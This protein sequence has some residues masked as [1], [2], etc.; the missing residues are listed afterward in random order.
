MHLF[1]GRYSEKT[2]RE[3]KCHLQEMPKEPDLTLTLLPLTRSL[4]SFFL[5]SFSFVNPSL[6]SS[7]PFFHFQ[8]ARHGPEAWKASALSASSNQS[9]APSHP[10]RHPLQTAPSTPSSS[11]PSTFF[12]S[13][14][15]SLD[16]RHTY[17]GS[18]DSKLQSVS[19]Q[20]HNSS[21]KVTRPSLVSQIQPRRSISSS[22][23]PPS[24]ASLEAHSNRRKDL[25]L[26]PKLPYLPSP[27][28]GRTGSVTHSTASS[29]SKTGRLPLPPLIPRRL[30]LPTPSILE[31]LKLPPLK[32]ALVQDR[33]RDRNE[34]DLETTCSACR[35]R[36]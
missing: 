20:S 29:P 12:T 26:L 27:E 30:E 6:I 24:A 23:H 7:A 13:K 34:P 3:W 33:D 10:I 5:L 9:E 16:K 25:K 35:Q 19:L 21:S 18:R 1:Y 2:H 17:S 15:P 22:S 11:H 4:S 28:D 31:Q 8:Y 36:G 32:M 14:R